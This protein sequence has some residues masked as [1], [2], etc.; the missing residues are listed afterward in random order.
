MKRR[1]FLKIA[2]AVV[3]WGPLS[4][5]SARAEAWTSKPFAKK[6][7]RTPCDAPAG[8]WTLVLLPDTQYYSQKYPEVAERQAEWIVANRKT[9]NIR[10]VAHEGDLVNNPTETKQWSR[11]QKALHI[12]RD[13]GVP[14]SLTTGNHDLG[15]QAGGDTNSRATL[16]NDYFD[17]GDYHNSKAMGLF[18]PEH[19]ENSWHVFSAPDG[20]YLLLALEFGPRDEVLAWANEVVGQHADHKV[21]L[22]T[23]AYLFHDSQRDTWALD[24]ARGGRSNPKKY[25]IFQAGDMNDGQ[26]IWDKLVSKHPNFLFTFNGHVCG[27]GVGHLASPGA[28]GGIVHQILAN[29]QD[30]SPKEAGTVHPARGYGGGGFLRLVQ[31]QPGGKMVQIK[32]YSPWYDEWLSEPEQQFTVSFV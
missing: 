12:L 28:G 31:F 2:A 4:W 32:S 19:M 6:I 15:T 14:F 1:T 11:I 18:E 5:L 20:K 21:I 25:P 24:E 3:A 29:Y 13:G 10:F 9:H 22:V 30:N 26:D 7:P 23:H 8:S 17:A 27:S 16:L